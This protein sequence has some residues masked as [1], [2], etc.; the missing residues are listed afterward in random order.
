MAADPVRRPPEDLA[1][2]TAL[3]IPLI[4]W[5]V[6][7]HFSMPGAWL[8]PD[9]WWWPL[10]RLLR[11]CLSVDILFVLSGY[12]LARV[13][14]DIDYSQAGRFL[15]TR[16]ARV[17]PMHLLGLLLCLP[18][19]L[20]AGTYAPAT[21]PLVLLCCGLCLQA[22]IPA[23]T[24]AI[25]P[26]SWYLSV[27]AFLCACF[28]VLQ[29]L[30]RRTPRASTCLWWLAGAWLL[31]TIPCWLLTR[32]D[33]G[34]AGLTLERNHLA[35]GTLA[36]LV[37]FLPLVHLPEFVAGM[38]LCAWHRHRAWSGDGRLLAPLGAAILLVGIVVGAGVLPFAPAL[39]G[40]FLPAT[41]LLVLG[42][43]DRRW[44]DGVLAHPAISLLGRSS[45]A[46]FLLHTPVAMVA[47]ALQ[48]RSD[49]LAA[50]PDPAFGLLV[51]AAAQL[52]AIAA[53][54]W[55]EEPLRRRLRPNRP[56]E[57]HR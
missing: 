8:D 33:P 6:A 3:R 42:L 31:A 36:H 12:L 52:S 37:K 11:S 2:L 27:D 23:W 55:V 22:W 19:V 49:L 5:V 43:A 47:H 56:A 13:H 57:V 25:N 48:K 21:L 40:L 24:L 26:P 34:L 38:L 17:L 32:A 51:L 4:W 15:R 50:L 20:A 9:G 18:F 46:L 39:N 29:P 53:L 54:R 1:G 41:C 35:D 14:W 7:Y 45:F 16:A 44:S 10:A 28:P 30:M